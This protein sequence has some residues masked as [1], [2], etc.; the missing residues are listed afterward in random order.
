M[1]RCVY[2]LVHGFTCRQMHI[3]LLDERKRPELLERPHVDAAVT[4]TCTGL[5]G[6]THRRLSARIL[7]A[8][9]ELS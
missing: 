6:E 5:T 1:N 9:H 3:S 4:G 7:M 8:M 2:Q